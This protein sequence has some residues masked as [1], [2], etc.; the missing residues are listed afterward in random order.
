VSIFVDGF[1]NWEE[2]CVVCIAC[3]VDF[4]MCVTHMCVT[5]TCV[6]LHLKFCVEEQVCVCASARALVY[7]VCG[8]Y[9][10]IFT[11]FHYA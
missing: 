10:N 3:V 4:Y 8:I 9:I 7:C 5:H 11:Y 6:Y 2:K 1:V